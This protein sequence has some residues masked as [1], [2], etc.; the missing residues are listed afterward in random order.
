MSKVLRITI[1]EEPQAKGRSRIV[2]VNGK[3]HSYTPERTKVAQ[4]AILLRLMRHQADCFPKDTPIKLTA[5]FYRTKSKYLPKR[6]TLPFRKPDLDNMLK[7]LSDAANGVLF[8]DDA[9]LTTIRVSKRWT[10]KDAGYI[11]IKL[12]EDAP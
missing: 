9:Q 3:F 6:E 5:V 1:Q 2:S 11:T 7:L 8:V 12:E 10:D 4:N